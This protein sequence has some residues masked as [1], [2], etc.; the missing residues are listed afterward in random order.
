MDCLKPTIFQAVKALQ[1]DYRHLNNERD[2]SGLVLG[3]CERHEQ[4]RADIPM[5]GATA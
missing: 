4:A 1:T 5:V 3:R 2:V